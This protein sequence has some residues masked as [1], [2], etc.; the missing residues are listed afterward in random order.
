MEAVNAFYDL[1]FPRRC[2][3]GSIRLNTTDR[4]ARDLKSALEVAAGRV[5]VCMHNTWGTV[6]SAG[7]DLPEAMVACQQLGYLTTGLYILSACT[8]VSSLP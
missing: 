3:D 7:F 4:R 6:C 2:I 5:E 1:S 8:C